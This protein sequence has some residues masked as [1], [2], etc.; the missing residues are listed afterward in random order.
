V[1]EILAGIWQELLHLERV[2]RYDNF[3]ELGGHSLHGVKLVAAVEARCGVRMSVVGV[4]RHPTIEEMAHAIDSLGFAEAE[5][6]VLQMDLG[7]DLEFEEGIIS[8]LYP[9]SIPPPH[10][11]SPMDRQ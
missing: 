8:T 3:F 11:P 6:H 5:P 1:E 2:G 4:F 9:S 10:A 7:E